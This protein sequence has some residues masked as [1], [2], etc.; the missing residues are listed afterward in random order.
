MKRLLARML[1]ESE[2]LSPFGIRALSRYHKDHPFVL[3]IS[4]ETLKVDYEPGESTTSLYGG[5]SNWRGPVWMPVNY[6]IIE[7]LRK[8]HRYYGDDFL[9]EYPTNSGTH[10]TIKEVA[11]ELA[12]RVSDSI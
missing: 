12:R 10:L 9:I 1:D 5:N 8:F 11:D 6:L 4:G 7:A 3:E 2:F